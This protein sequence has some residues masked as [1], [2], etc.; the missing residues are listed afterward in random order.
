[1]M[2]CDARWCRVTVRNPGGRPLASWWLTGSGAPDLAVVESLARL[3]L[4]ARRS[5]QGIRLDEVTPALGDLLD[6]AGL[7]GE[8][9]RKTEGREQRPGFEE[10]AEGADPIP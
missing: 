1:M 4:V 8:L 7:G 2:A 5:G 10:E 3:V 6:L 9:G